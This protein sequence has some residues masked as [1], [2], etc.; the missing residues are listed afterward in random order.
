M[1]V[2]DDVPG[3]GSDGEEVFIDDEDIINEI[4]LDEEGQYYTSTLS[5]QLAASSLLLTFA[6]CVCLLLPLLR[7]PRP[8]R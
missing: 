6:C 1:S 8:G 2:T 3:E 4:P 5:P 7:S